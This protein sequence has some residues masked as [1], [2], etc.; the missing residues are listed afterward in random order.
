MGRAEIQKILRHTGYMARK[1]VFITTSR[2]NREAP[3]FISMI[4]MNIRLIDG[5]KLAELTV[6]DGRGTC[7]KPTSH[8]ADDFSEDD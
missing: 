5:D 6:T 3:V 2:F 4:E 1:E 7:V 8:S